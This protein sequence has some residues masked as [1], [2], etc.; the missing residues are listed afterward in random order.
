MMDSIR[1][2]QAREWSSKCYAC[3]RQLGYEQ[4][5]PISTQRRK[6]PKWEFST[7][8]WVQSSFAMLLLLRCCD[9]AQSNS[10]QEC[11]LEQV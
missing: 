3:Q 9:A 11:V 2:R 7:R 4:V 8:K 6:N 5:R 1:S 10:R